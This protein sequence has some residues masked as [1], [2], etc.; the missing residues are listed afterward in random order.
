MIEAITLTFN[1]GWTVE[2]RDVPGP[3]DDIRAIRACLVAAALTPESGC[4]ADGT[5]PL[6]LRDPDGNPVLIDQHR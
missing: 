2:G 3:F 6:I 1:P 5:A 4:D